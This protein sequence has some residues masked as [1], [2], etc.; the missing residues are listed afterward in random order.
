M[1][2]P[3]NACGFSPASAP[4]SSPASST[5]IP[6]PTM[7]RAP[8]PFGSRRTAAGSS[9]RPER[10]MRVSSA[11]GRM[12]RP[13]SWAS[14]G[15]ARRTAPAIAPPF[16]KRDPRK[17]FAHPRPRPAPTSTPKGI[18]V[19]KFFNWILV[20]GAFVG[21]FYL[22]GLIVPRNQTQGSKTTLTAKPD[23]L[24]KVVN[25]PTTWCDWHPDVASIQERPGRNDHPVWEV[26]DKHGRTFDME[27][28][29][30]EDPGAWQGTY[31]IDGT[32]FVLRFDLSWYGQGGRARVTA[33]SDTRDTW[34]RAKRFLLP[35]NESS[36]SALLN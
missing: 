10:S 22:I 15:V 18:A 26:K 30:Q 7:S 36:E 20:V 12:V 21:A 29:I 17:S 25:D 35:T 33:T 8:S 27:V 23:A 1:P 11:V 2:T 6:S 4:R 24:Y 9:T 5:V 32:R 16:R 3:A 14:T 19:K 34:K 13:S 31:T 28:Q